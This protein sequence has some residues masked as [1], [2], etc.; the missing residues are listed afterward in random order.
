MGNNIS[1]TEKT[2]GCGCLIG[3]AIGVVLSLLAMLGGNM[4]DPR[5]LLIFIPL[6]GLFCASI[7]LAIFSPEKGVRGCAGCICYPIFIIVA[8]VAFFNRAMA[9]FW[10]VIVAIVILLLLNLVRICYEKEQKEKDRQIANKFEAA[11]SKQCSDLL[12]DETSTEDSKK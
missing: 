5:P 2:A 7:P 12:P 9:V 6:V 8:L 11:L 1:K 3:L 10:G 4:R